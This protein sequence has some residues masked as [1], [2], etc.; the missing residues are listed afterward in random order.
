MAYISINGYALPPC[1]RGVRIVLTTAVNAGRDGNGAVVGQ[2]IGRDQY[3]IDGLEWAWLTAS[4][5]QRILSLL[6][7][8]YVKI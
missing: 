8:F 5:W 2:R 1:K 3:K 6:Q 4:E 7:N